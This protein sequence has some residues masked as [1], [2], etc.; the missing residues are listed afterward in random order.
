MTGGKWMASPGAVELPPHTLTIRWKRPWQI[1]MKGA[2][3]EVSVRFHAEAGRLY[4]V[5]WK[6]T[7]DEWKE[8]SVPEWTPRIEVRSE[9]R[10]EWV[11]PAK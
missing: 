3:G 4:Y 9:P 8:R 6:S 2:R 11:Y 7:T 1:W 10:P 5:E